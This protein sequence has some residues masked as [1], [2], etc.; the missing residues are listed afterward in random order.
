VYRT[1]YR[2]LASPARLAMRSGRS[3]DLEIIALRLQLG[4]LRR[5]ID[6]LQL[7][8]D[9]RTLLGAIAAALPTHDDTA[10]S[11]PSIRSCAGTGA[12]SQIDPMQRT[13]QPPDQQRRNSRA[14][15]WAS[16]E[17]NT[18]WTLATVPADNGPPFALPERPKLGIQLIDLRCG[19]LPDRD[20]YEG[21][22][23][24]QA[25]CGSGGWWSAPTT[26]TPR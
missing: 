23:S 13:H 8:N 22:G 18:T 16:A 12:A 3:K 26:S 25:R 14:P 24:G 11:S 10:G 9:D 5:R 20:R 17:R 21:G 2:L 7:D 1:L 4:V 15:H 6:R 19:Q